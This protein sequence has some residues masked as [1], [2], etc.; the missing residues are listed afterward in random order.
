MR[1]IT[2]LIVLVI[3]SLSGTA[4][5]Q[6]KSFKT[7]C[8][9]GY[10]KKVQ[11]NRVTDDG[12]NASLEIEL[13]ITGIPQINNPKDTKVIIEDTSGSGQWFEY[14]YIQRYSDTAMTAM[15]YRLPVRLA[16]RNDSCTDTYRNIV[17]QACTDFN[18]CR[19]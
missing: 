12:E 19:N 8:G 2:S 18:S 15:Q 7:E 14:S 4:H 13:D 9:I 17:I 11:Q 5:S 10:I 6:V 16:S 1:K 3:L